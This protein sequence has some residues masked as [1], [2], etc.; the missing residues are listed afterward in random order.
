MTSND[1]PLKTSWSLS[2]LIVPIFSALLWHTYIDHHG[3]GF[4]YVYQPIGFTL[5]IFALFQSMKLWWKWQFPYWIPRIFIVSFCGLL[6]LVEIDVVHFCFLGLLFSLFPTRYLK[7]SLP[8]FLVLSSIN[9]DLEFL[10]N[11][12]PMCLM[13]LIIE[14]PNSIPT[15][16]QHSSKPLEAIFFSSAIIG[17]FTSAT[18]NHFWFILTPERTDILLL[19]AIGIMIHGVMTP[20]IRTELYTL[21]IPVSWI[22]LGWMSVQPFSG[23]ELSIGIG[24]LLAFM[25]SGLPRSIYVYGGLGVGL[26]AQSLFKY[27]FP[28]TNGFF[29]LSVLWFIFAQR[30]ILPSLGAIT[31]GII[32]L[33]ARG[34]VISNSPSTLWTTYMNRIPTHDIWDNNGWYFVERLDNSPSQLSSFVNNQNQTRLFIEN[35]PITLPFNNKSN[36]VEFAEI[37][38]KWNHNLEQI[39]ILSDIS[40]HVNTVFQSTDTQIHLQ[41]DHDIRTQFIAEQEDISKTNWLK[42]NRIIHRATPTELIHELNQLNTVIEIV[43]V[44]WESTISTGL[45]PVH[46]K[47][48]KSALSTNGTYFLIVDLHSFPNEGLQKIT[49]NL[50][51]VFSNHLYMLPKDNIDSVMI[52]AQDKPFSF[53][54][55]KDHL[56]DDSIPIL[57]RI[58][59]NR[60]P[61]SKSSDR[62]RISVKDRPS[63]PFTHLTALS[64]LTLEP[65]DIWSDLTEQDARSLAIEFEHHREYLLIVEE[66]VKGNIEPIQHHNLPVELQRSLI[67]PHVQAAKKHIIAAQLEG[68]S[69][70]EWS[71]AQRYALTAQMIAPT[72]AEPWILLGEIALGEGFLEK[73]EEKFQHIYSE[74]PTSLPAINGLARIAGLKEDYKRTE[75]LLLEAQTAAPTNWTTHYNLAVFHQEH[76][77]LEM[78]FTLLTKAL[79]LP[80]GDNLKTRIALTEY[81][82]AQQRWTR[83]LL[84]IDRLIQQDTEPEAKLWFLRGRIHFGLEI[85]DKAEMDFRKATLAD[86]NFHAARGS[87]GVIKMIQGDLE[88][89]AQA[90][91]ATLRFDPNNEAAR[92]NLQIVQERLSNP[93]NR[94]SP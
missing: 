72:E 76:G 3:W 20:W 5:T 39:A 15:L 88:G 91:R 21:T 86:P 82:I 30:K 79:E 19:T 40:G 74:D 37:I 32:W 51:T 46:F 89:A 35:T 90:F 13:L 64:T 41:T 34:P 4:K 45:T 36:H 69:S 55:L 54:E 80:N 6:Y 94:P 83:A 23:S 10:K 73:A 47:R 85:W 93:S 44:P 63:I 2:T 81:F 43:H 18:L 17:L 29:T 60:Y 62:K 31:F 25:Y 42:P 67:Q 14:K 61:E 68:Q 8:I 7:V 84:E 65:S 56:G 87:I 70:T 22:V 11:W 49:H 50:E 9:I 24:F 1:S 92:Q 75:A 58:L 27:T 77:T 53:E 38:N 66:G 57:G 48:V 71:Q 59:T 16:D 52:I 26:I 33:S 28:E 12:A 78:A